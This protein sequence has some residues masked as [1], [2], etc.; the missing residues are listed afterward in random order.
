M[1]A[2]SVAAIVGRIAAEWVAAMVR[3][4]RLA[5]DAIVAGAVVTANR[6]LWDTAVRGRTHTA[7]PAAP[8]PTGD[9]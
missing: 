3:S 1:R 5:G 9:A 4:N 6:C 7:T 8:A 2:V